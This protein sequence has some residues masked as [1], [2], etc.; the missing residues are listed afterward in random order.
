MTK[1]IAIIG[2]G[3]A[4]TACAYILKQAGLEPVIYEASS[5]LATAASGNDLGLYNSR[6]TAEFGPEA[7]YYTSAFELA[8]A[9]FPTLGDIEWSPCGALHLINDEKKQ[10]RFHKTVQNWPWSDDDMR[11]VSAD[12]ATALAGIAIHQDALYL[13]K[14]GHVCPHKLCAAYAKDVEVHVNHPMTDL[15]DI[16]ADVIILAAGQGLINLPETKHLP[17]KAVRGQVTKIKAT[18]ASAQIKCNIQYGGYLSPAH[19]EGWHVVGS[20]FQ[21][22]LDHSDLIEEDNTQNL[23]KLADHVPALAEES[24]KILAAR[25][26]VRVTT[27]DHFPIIGALSDNLYISAGHGSHGIVSS[28]AAARHICEA[29]T[30]QKHSLSNDAIER[31]SP[32][33]YDRDN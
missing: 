5:Q 30:G 1:R 14:A 18:Q 23:Q 8:H 27:P 6:F 17:L 25:A 19:A 2:G 3:L 12:E 7:Q 13:A 22:W 20:T 29:I 16:Q 11:I 32:H 28:I 26:G 10:R 31:I 21:R 9:T 15:S 24:W 33:R 4:G